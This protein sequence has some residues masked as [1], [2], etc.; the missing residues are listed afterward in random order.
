MAPAVWH[1]RHQPERQRAR[2]CAHQGDDR[3][4][5][6]REGGQ[7][8]REDPSRQGRREDDRVALHAPRARACVPLPF[9]PDIP[10][11]DSTLLT[12]F[13]VPLHRRPPPVGAPRLVVV[14]CSAAQP[15]MRLPER[16]QLA[17]RLADRLAQRV[18]DDQGPACRPAADQGRPQSG[19]WRHLVGRQARQRPK[20]PGQGRRER[21]RLVSSNL[22]HPRIVFSRCRIFARR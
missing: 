19:W 11:A 22:G 12:R 7:D 17:Q 14:E 3:R 5:D 18:A 6:A 4:P 2:R 13:L 8:W 16:L 15:L 9:G 1:S 10:A 20:G 21:Q